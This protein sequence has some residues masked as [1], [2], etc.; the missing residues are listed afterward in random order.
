[1]KNWPRH[2][3][4]GLVM[5]ICIGL[6]VGLFIIELP[7]GNREVAL[8]VLG[9]AIGWGSAVVQFHFGSSEGSKEKS[10]HIETLTTP[11]D[12]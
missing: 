6:L 4:G 10:V 3:V 8:T 7:A 9:L 11:D 1:M 12:E 5:L 2:A